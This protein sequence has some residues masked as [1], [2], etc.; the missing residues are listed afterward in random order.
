MSS[1]EILLEK[2]K[3]I[4]DLNKALS[5]MSWD[6]ETNMP[7]AG[8]TARV[9]QMTTLS[10]LT[11]QMFTSDEMGR[12]IADSLAELT[13][14]PYDSNEASLMRLVTRM[15][16]NARKLPPEFVARVSEV[17]G[18]AHRPGCRRGRRMISLLFGRGWS[19]W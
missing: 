15:Y 10:R 3:E 19:R 4:D 5:L 16:D 7:K 13:D 6:R 1:Y 18:H 11:H 9:Q 14:A 8:V 2:V 17:S 12:L